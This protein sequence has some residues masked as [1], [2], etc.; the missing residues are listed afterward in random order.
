MD[1]IVQVS[2]VEILQSRTQWKVRNMNTDLGVNVLVGWVS[3]LSLRV[4]IRCPGEAT[5]C[6]RTSKLQ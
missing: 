4:N 6:I 3:S 2:S 5:S 1:K